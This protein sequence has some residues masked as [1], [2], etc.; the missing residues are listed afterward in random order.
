MKIHFVDPKPIKL[1]CCHWDCEAD[2]GYQIW[3]EPWGPDCFTD[4][5]ADHVKELLEPGRKNMVYQLE[6]YCGEYQ[7]RRLH[8]IEDLRGR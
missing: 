3:W 6:E 2:A 8:A 1:W 4:S 7:A 5:C